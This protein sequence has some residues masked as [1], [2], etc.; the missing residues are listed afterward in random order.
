ME[1]FKNQV[2]STPEELPGA[3][4]KAWNNRDTYEIVELF[5]ESAELEN[6]EDLWRHKNKEIFSAYENGLRFNFKELQLS[7][8]D[9][10]VKPITST[11]VEVKVQIKK[12]ALPAGKGKVKEG[13]LLLNFVL[14]KYE[15]HWLCIALTMNT[16]R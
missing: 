7:L 10:N 1:P 11:I 12:E 14:Q 8:I 5:E 2:I 6:V 4:V 9:F 3:F 15:Q 16:L 13:K